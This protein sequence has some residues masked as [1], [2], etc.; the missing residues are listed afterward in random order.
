M[1]ME[2]FMINIRRKSVPTFMSP[3]CTVRVYPSRAT[4]AKK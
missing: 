3:G 2:K 4:G 1:Y